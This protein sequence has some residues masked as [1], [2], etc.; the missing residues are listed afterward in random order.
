MKSTWASGA[1]ELLKHADSH[2][3]LNTAFDKRIAF[4]SIDNCVETIIRTYIS[5]PKAKSGIKVKKQELDEAGNSFPKLL[6][7]LFKY[8]P[9]KLVGIDEIDIEHYH[10]IRNKLYH[11]GTGLSVDDEYLIAYRGIAGVLL[12]N[13]F[14]VS[15]KPSASESDSLGK[16]ILNWN[17]IEHEIKDKLEK[18]GISGTYKWEEAF[19]LGLVEPSDIQ[20]LTELRMAR[21][22]L[23]HSESIDKEDI[24]Y[25]L[26]VSENLLP[27]IKAAKQVLSAE[28][29][30]D[31]LEAPI[32]ATQP[33]E[34]IIRY[35]KLSIESKIHK[36][37]L[38]IS[39]KLL[40]TPDQDFFR[41]SFLWP[42][43]IPISKMVGF[44]EGEEQN[45]KGQIY[46][47]YALF[48]DKRLW[49]GQTMK[50]VGGKSTAI[51]EYEFNNYV[52]MNRH[53]TPFDLHYT[54]FLQNWQPVQGSI[55]FESLN[56]F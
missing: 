32:E 44:E 22:R 7:L 40:K 37:A 17:S 53:S 51:L 24:K 10:R 15:I 25:W 23:V 20:L 52:Y 18:A 2:I 14:D 33:A 56:I 13:L 43:Q 3:D 27:K 50:I 55:S 35:K 31:T 5:L 8:T 42:A 28:Q 46:K 38:E 39:V 19:S 4:I 21:N 34:I 41:I 48:I 54:L 26:E 47:E 12:K 6:S 49:P 45:I 16:L 30:K 29:K 9:A 36:Y 1:I 11:D